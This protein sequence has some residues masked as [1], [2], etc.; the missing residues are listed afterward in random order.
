MLNV[1]E[2]DG[3]IVIYNHLEF[4]YTCEQNIVGVRLQP[5]NYIPPSIIL[6]ARNV[7]I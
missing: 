5:F 6:D 4:R 3:H 7:Y 1:R 2:T